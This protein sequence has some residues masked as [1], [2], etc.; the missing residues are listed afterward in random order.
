M[1]H[2]G[3]TVCRLHRENMAEADGM[4]SQ[5][6]RVRGAGGKNR[7]HAPLTNLPWKRE[8][9]G[10]ENREQRWCLTSWGEKAQGR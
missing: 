1:S 8:G 10:E 2:G 7:G 6:R 5:M 4:A 3:C 9:G